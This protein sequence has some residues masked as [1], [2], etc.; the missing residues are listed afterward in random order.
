MRKRRW[1][2]GLRDARILVPNSRLASVRRRVA[3]EVARLGQGNEDE[4]LNWIEAVSEFDSSDRQA[5][6]ERQ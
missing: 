2:R 5:S 4:A 6:D 3:V 1:K